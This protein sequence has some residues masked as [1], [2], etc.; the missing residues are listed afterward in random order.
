MAS[1]TAVIAA[2][3]W[4]AVMIGLVWAVPSATGPQATNSMWV[5]VTITVA[6]F[7][8]SWR[9]IVPLRFGEPGPMPLAKA[10]IDVAVLGIAIGISDGLSGPF[11]ACLIVAVAVAG[12]GWG[13]GAGMFNGALGVSLAALSSLLQLG[14]NEPATTDQFP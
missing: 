8:T 6:I 13:L 1:L 14:S 7:I 5:I 3:R 2:L 12:F 4:G 11:T 10:S 9:T